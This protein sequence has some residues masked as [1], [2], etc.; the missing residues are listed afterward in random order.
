MGIGVVQ[1]GIMWHKM[2]EKTISMVEWYWKALINASWN[3]CS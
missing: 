1:S 3:S 2:L